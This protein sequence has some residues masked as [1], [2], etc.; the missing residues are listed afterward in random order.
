MTPELCRLNNTYLIPFDCVINGKRHSDRITNAVPPPENS[1]SLPPVPGAYE[2]MFDRF[3][4]A[5]HKVI[6]I[7]T[8]RKIS[9]AYENATGAAEKFSPD[10]LRVIDSGVVAGGLYLMVRQLR[11]R[12]GDDGD[13][14]EITEFLEDYKKRLCVK[15][16]TNTTERLENTNR[17][18]ANRAGKMFVPDQKPIFVMEE[19]AII[20]KTT[21]SPGFREISELVSVLDDPEYVV[22]HYLEKNEYLHEIG[23]AI[24]NKCPK[25]KIF[26]FPITLSLKINLGTS[27]IGIIGD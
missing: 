16:T 26:T 20:C 6:C 8:S 14:D 1:Y 13:I 18:T 3:I 22:L 5:G 21:A 15:F 12:F 19:G 27:I 2:K 11:E 4:S 17:L 25:A 23:V 9:R 10:S 7:T 24:K